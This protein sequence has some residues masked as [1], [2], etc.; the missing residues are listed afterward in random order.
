MCVCVCVRVRVRV[1]VCTC[2][3][4]VCVCVCMCV[5][6][7]TR[8]HVCVCVC[9]EGRSENRLSRSCQQP[10]Q[11]FLPLTSAHSSLMSAPQ[12]AAGDVLS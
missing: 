8:M 7:C 4:C 12:S 1:C 2:A 6:V 11:L 10:V 3:V 5:C 9:V